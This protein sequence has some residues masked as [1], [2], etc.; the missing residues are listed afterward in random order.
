VVDA[1]VGKRI[2]DVFRIATLPRREELPDHRV[3]RGRGPAVGYDRGR[4]SGVGLR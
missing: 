2:D 1:V 4:Y 3:V